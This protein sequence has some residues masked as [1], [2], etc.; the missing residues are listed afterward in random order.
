MTHSGCQQTAAAATTVSQEKIQL[1]FS[2][3]I[4]ILRADFGDGTVCYLP[5]AEIQH[6]HAQWHCYRSRTE[7]RYRWCAFRSPHFLHFARETITLTFLSSPHFVALFRRNPLKKFILS[8]CCHAKWLSQSIQTKEVT[9]FFTQLHSVRNHELQLDFS[10]KL[11]TYVRHTHTH[12][13]HRPISRKQYR[14]TGTMGRRYS[15]KQCV[16]ERKSTCI[17]III[18]NRMRYDF[19]R[20]RTLEIS[21]VLLRIWT[22]H[23]WRRWYPAAEKMKNRT[24]RLI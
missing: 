10:M 2:F 23:T 4:S 24:H 6:T 5:S 22:K 3:F 16:S 17:N 13:I 11:K 1:F 15:S 21:H 14:D 20:S 19:Q 8:N 18:V 9:T 12:V 7:H